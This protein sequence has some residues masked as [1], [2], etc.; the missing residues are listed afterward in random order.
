MRIFSRLSV[1]VLGL[2]VSST[3]VASEPVKSEQS[4]NLA[5]TLLHHFHFV[6]PYYIASVYTPHCADC[7]RALAE[8]T[9]QVKVASAFAAG[10][11]L[12]RASNILKSDSAA[13]HALTGFL[14]L[15]MGYDSSRYPVGR[16]LQAAAINETGLA[17]R[18]LIQESGNSDHVTYLAQQ[19]VGAILLAASLTFI[20]F[21]NFAIVVALGASQL[22]GGFAAPILG[23][24]SISA[25]ARPAY[26]FSRGYVATTMIS[27]ALVSI[28]GGGQ[29][30][31]TIAFGMFGMARLL[32]RQAERSILRFTSAEAAGMLVPLAFELVNLSKYF[33]TSLSWTP[34]KE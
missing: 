18:R 14:F 4:K 24:I 5:T 27:S 2:I 15:G 29:T 22:A 9:T 20:P 34:S 30:R 28:L 33:V 25:A 19:T 17:L 3:L 7:N 21:P 32:N 8:L 13:A 16:Y 10:E 26:F 6:V 31:A 1:C 12:A 11:E 23:L